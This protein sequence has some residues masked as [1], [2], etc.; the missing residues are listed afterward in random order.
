MEKQDITKGFQNVYK[1][2]TDFLVKFL[3][4]ASRFPSVLDCFETQLKWLDIQPGNHILD[5]GCG[6]GDQAKEIAKRVGTNGRVTGTDLS[7][8]MIEVSQSRHSNAGLPLE[9]F[10]AD[11][12]QHPFRDES[13]DRIRTERVLMYVKNTDEAFREFTRLLKP[14][15]KLMVFDL[16][17]DALVFAHSDKKLTRKIMDFISDSFPCGRIGTDLFGYFKNFGFSDVKVKSFG[18]TPPLEF[19]KRVC[20]GIIQTGI[21]GNVF[22]QDEITH[23]WAALDR[24]N[25]DNKFFMAFQGY[26]VVGTK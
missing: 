5:I 6:I 16:D 18:Y 1:A 21:S 23:W 7:N 22:T 24:D 9:F 26:L 14:N 15:G 11:A 20:E 8:T 13:F 19:A 4:D 25:E 12:L 17:W 3:E 10:V 2:Q